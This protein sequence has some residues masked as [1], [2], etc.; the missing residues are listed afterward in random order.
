M[1][2]HRSG[3]ALLVCIFVVTLTTMLVM[4][5]LEIQTTETAALRNTADYERAL[6]LAGAAAHHA[7]AEL[8]ADS[9]WRDG[10]SLT[11]YPAGSG[12]TYSATI[13]DGAPGQVV[14]SGFGTAGAVTRKVDVTV[15][16]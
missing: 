4:S 14:I 13:L 11:E 15:E 6:Y 16:L 12:F 10:I 7:L 3:A 5:M 2:G 1:N 9:S 8:E